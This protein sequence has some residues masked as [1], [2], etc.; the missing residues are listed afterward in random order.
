MH[1]LN[2]FTERIGKRIYRGDVTCDCNTCKT[3]TEEGLIIRDNTHAE[4]LYDVQLEMD[5]EYRD[6]K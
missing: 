1:P 2:W 3:G 4:Y 6:E 5:I